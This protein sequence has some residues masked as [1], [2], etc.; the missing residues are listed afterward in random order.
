MCAWSS[1]YTASSQPAW[2]AR[3]AQG[4]PLDAAPRQCRQRPPPCAAPALL[5]G[6]VGPGLVDKLVQG[7]GR[8]R[9]V[10]H[11]LRKPHLAGLALGRA[12]GHKR[13]PHRLHSG[14]ARLQRR[15]LDIHPQSL[16]C[17]GHVGHRAQVALQGQADK[18]DGGH[19]GCRAAAGGVHGM[20]R[21]LSTESTSGCSPLSQA[22]NLHKWLLSG[23]CP[24]GV[25]GAGTCET[26]QQGGP[27]AGG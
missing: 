23:S 8:G 25:L 4:L 17:G 9:G 1:G 13:H 26:T 14:S 15:K 21:C 18:E 27:E 19:D 22:A 6:K 7:N 3:V 10:A 2:W 11:A 16:H 12:Q 5:T 24:G 20:G